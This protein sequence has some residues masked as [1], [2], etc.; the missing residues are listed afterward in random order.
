MGDRLRADAGGLVDALRDAG[1][2]HVAMV[3]G[4]RARGRARRSARR[5]GLD[6]VY[7]EQ[8]PEEKLGV[9]RAMRRPPELRPVVMV[10]DGVND[11][12][13]LALADVGIAMAGDGR[14]RLRPRPPTP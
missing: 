10:G 1:V 4:D 13:A 14:D 6:R 7:A 12:P 11:A 3:T 9:V 8:T 2:R 5:L